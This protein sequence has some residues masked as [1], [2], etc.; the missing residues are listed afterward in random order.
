MRVLLVK[1]SSMGDLIHALPALTDAQHAIPGI[2]FDW[3]IEES[4][5]EIA[6]WHPAVDKIIT[7][8]HRRWRKQKW[9]VLHNGELINFVKNLRST[10][11]D[12]VIDGQTNW[13]SALVTRL[14]RGLRCGLDSHSAREFV[15]PWAYQKK[16]FVPKAEHAVNRLR[17]LFAQILGYSYPNT[18]PDFALDVSKFPKPNLTLPNEYLIF[19][20]NASWE[21]KLWPES[22]WAE[23]LKIVTAKNYS[24]LLP[25]GNAA[26]HERAVRLTQLNPKII[27]LPHLSLSE[28][29]YIISRAKAA[30]CN[31]TGLSHITA[32]VH[33]PSVNLYGPTDSGLI[34][35]PG[36]LQV[37]LQADFPCAPCYQKQCTY[38]KSSTERPAC[39]TQLPPEL[40]WSKL[41]PLLAPR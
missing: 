29:A 10:H 39:F 13:K 19:I 2:R 28:M 5:A 8:A 26:E 9:D 41:Q 3:V 32:A 23:L 22:Y 4:F 14:S 18:A 7:T 6:Q 33:V 34:G 37:Y 15:A 30:V 27:A 31:D 12:L 11:Y 35:A 20:H 25:S 16:I 24:V 21:S 40:V 17:M 36:K 38:Q 1:L